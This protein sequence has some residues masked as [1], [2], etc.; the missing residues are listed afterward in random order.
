MDAKYFNIL[1]I[2]WTIV[3]L[4]IPLCIGYV[5]MD[6]GMTKGR[7]EDGNGMVAEWLKN[8]RR[9]GLE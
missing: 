4:G 3:S 9:M 1:I 8:V 7:L 6:L 2:V 5:F